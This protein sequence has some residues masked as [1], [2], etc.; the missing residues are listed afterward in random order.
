MGRAEKTVRE[1]KNINKSI[2]ALEHTPAGQ[3]WREDAGKVDWEHIGRVLV[4]MMTTLDFVLPWK[5]SD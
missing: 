3:V 4:A 5:A 1:E 2:E